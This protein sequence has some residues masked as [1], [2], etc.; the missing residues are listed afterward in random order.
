MLFFPSV[1]DTHPRMPGRWSWIAVAVFA[2]LA[3][4]SI[5]SFAVQARVSSGMQSASAWASYR[6]WRLS[7]GGSGDRPASDGTLDRLGGWCS[8]TTARGSI[9]WITW[10]AVVV[11]CVCTSC[12]HRGAAEGVD[13]STQ[14]AKESSR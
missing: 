11:T 10:E 9:P 5:T 12:R 13:T 3:F 4:S 6:P 14:I 1:L 8:H 7:T 2:A